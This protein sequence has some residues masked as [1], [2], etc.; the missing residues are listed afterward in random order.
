MSSHARVLLFC[1]A[2][3]VS[4]FLWSLGQRI[5]GDLVGAAI[6]IVVIAAAVLYAYAGEPKPPADVQPGSGAKA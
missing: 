5:G 6:C 1:I 3:L 4:P 2:I